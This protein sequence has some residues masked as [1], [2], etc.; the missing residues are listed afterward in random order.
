MEVRLLGTGGWLPSDRRETAC[1]ALREGADLLLLDAGTGLRRLATEPALIEGVERLHVALSHFHLDHTYGLM[2]MP[3]LR[4]LRAR[5]VWAP[6]RLVA[7]VDGEELVHRLLDPPFLAG[8]ADDV[9]RQLVTAVHELD[10]TAEIGPFRVETRVQ[11]LHNG[12]TL[13]LRVNG[14]LVYCTDTAYDT[15]NGVF[16]RGARVLLHEAFDAA[17]TTENP[18]HSAAGE[19]GRIAA[20]AGV[21]RLVVVHVSPLGVDEERLAACARTRFE[22]SEVG[23]DG[24]VL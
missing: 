4:S 13:A 15:E 1:V 20:A 16:A 22:A 2:A 5:E 10:E 14:E 19:A 24:L 7:G 21:E 8:D 6:G 11:P 18:Q 3:A 17:D 9:I 12:P 23:R